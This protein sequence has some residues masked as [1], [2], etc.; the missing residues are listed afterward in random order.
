MVTTGGRRPP[1]FIWAAQ[2]PENKSLLDVDS[3][4]IID[5][6]LNEVHS[7]AQDCARNRCCRPFQHW[8][9]GQRGDSSVCLDCPIVLWETHFPAQWPHE[10]GPIMHY[11]TKCSGSCSSYDSS[12]AEWFKISELSVESAGR[13][14][15]QANIGAPP[16][17][18]YLRFGLDLLDVDHSG[19]HARKR[20]H[21][22]QHC[23]W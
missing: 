21:P 2:Y 19:G 14:W 12:N 7:W 1:S 10:T 5:L 23:S 11:M 8:L 6:S 20:D 9:G 16:H 13:T 3:L 22:F 18:L 15:Y 4:Q 17:Q